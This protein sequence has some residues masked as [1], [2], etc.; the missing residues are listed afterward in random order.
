M[1]KLILCETLFCDWGAAGAQHLGLFNTVEQTKGYG[2]MVA[3]ATGDEK[4]EWGN[5]NLYFSISESTWNV[6]WFPD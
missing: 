4:A 5:R 2:A 6:V 3:N 1:Q